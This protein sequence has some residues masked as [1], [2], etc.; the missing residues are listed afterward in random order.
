M[1]FLKSKVEGFKDAETGKSGQA[2]LTE[3][4]KQT[5]AAYKSDAAD[6]KTDYAALAKGAVKDF[7]GAQPGK[8]GEAEHKVDAAAAPTK[9]AQ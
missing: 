5:Y 7:G 1:N 9:P 2:G 3:Q 6:G 4:A 8:I